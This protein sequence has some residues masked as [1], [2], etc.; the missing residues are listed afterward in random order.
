LFH[1]DERRD[2]K[3]LTVAFWNFAKA[4][5][6]DKDLE[7]VTNDMRGYKNVLVRN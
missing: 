5:I 1:A 6:N 4:P 2:I 3:E 7:G